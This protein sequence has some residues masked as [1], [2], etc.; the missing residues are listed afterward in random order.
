MDERQ[1]GDPPSFVDKEEN[2][3]APPTPLLLSLPSPPGRERTEKL[4]RRTVKSVLLIVKVNEKA[5][6][7]CP[8]LLY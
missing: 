3:G 8:P 4:S 5:C 1:D 7:H 6:F 2:M